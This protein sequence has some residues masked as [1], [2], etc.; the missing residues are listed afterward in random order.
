MCLSYVFALVERARLLQV[1]QK[2]LESLS[3]VLQTA[4]KPSQLPTHIELQI[5]NPVPFASTPGFWFK[6]EQSP[7]GFQPSVTSATG[8]NWNS[9]PLD[10][11]SRQCDRVEL[12]D[13]TIKPSLLC[14][15]FVF[16][17]NAN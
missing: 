3:A 14:F 11:Q 4:A 5:K 1:G 12:R 16:L 7:I 17:S 2:A 6:N 8:S 10:R 15:L 13:W 9:L